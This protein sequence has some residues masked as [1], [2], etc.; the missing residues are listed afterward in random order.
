[1]SKFNGR[2][3]LSH[4]I[5][6]YKTGLVLSGGGTRGYAQI[7]AIKALEESGIEIDIIS[8]TSVGAIVG[9]MLADGYGAEQMYDVFSRYRIMGVSR[10]VICRK[11]LM[12]L[13][14]LKR[15]LRKYIRAS[16]F[17][18][19]QKP[20]YVAVTNLTQG[21]A[22]YI[23]EGPLDEM[24]IASASIPVIYT[25][26]PSRGELFTDGGMMDNFPVKAIRP[27]C[28]RII[29]INVMPV[30]PVQKYRHLKTAAFRTLQLYSDVINKPDT[31]QCDI[32]VEP[33]EIAEFGFLSSRKRKKLYE[34]GY[35][36]AQKVLKEVNL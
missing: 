33:G 20:L 6:K 11:G 34:L 18:E 9:V 24:I 13:D 19:L 12:S 27:V 30:N 35:R 23:H 15:P 7:G 32:L 14:G 29:G 28:D 2:T 4:K 10:L 5:M 31:R 36:E 21:K 1:V 3:D 16:R 25:P 17:E 22:E 26:V 8:G